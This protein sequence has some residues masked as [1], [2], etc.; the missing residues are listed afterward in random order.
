MHSR[1]I[2]FRILNNRMFLVK[3]RDFLDGNCAKCRELCVAFRKKCVLELQF[4]YK[5]GI[6][7]VV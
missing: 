2:H 3:T 5:A 4:E 7:L 6:L 1:T